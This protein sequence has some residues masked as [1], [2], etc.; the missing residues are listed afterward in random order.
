MSNPK[1]RPKQPRKKVALGL[2]LQPQVQ[3]QQQ[4][5]KNCSNVQFVIWDSL[6]DLESTPMSK[7]FTKFVSLKKIIAKVLHFLKSVIF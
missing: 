5:P 2:V 6:Q 4:Q 1:G 3:Q 7:I